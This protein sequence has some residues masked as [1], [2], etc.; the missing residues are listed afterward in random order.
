[1]VGKI[2]YNNTAASESGFLAK[3][4]LP[5]GLITN[6]KKPLLYRNGLFAQADIITENIRLLQRFYYNLARQIKR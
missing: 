4:V 6:Y 3:V 2:D 1:V 5:D